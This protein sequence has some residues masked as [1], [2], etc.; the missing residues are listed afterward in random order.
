[1]QDW[2]E[3]TNEMEEAKEKGLYTWIRTLEGPQ[4]AW[5]TIQSKKSA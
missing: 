4:G 5:L 1:M 3:L 2:M